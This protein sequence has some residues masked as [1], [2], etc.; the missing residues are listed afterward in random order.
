MTEEEVIELAEQVGL[1]RDGDMWFSNRKDYTDVHTTDLVTLVNEAIGKERLK[2]FL[3]KRR[4]K[5][6]N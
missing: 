4:N 6:D 2:K 3:A 5:N 1:M